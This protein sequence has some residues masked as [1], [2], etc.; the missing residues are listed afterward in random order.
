MEGEKSELPVASAE[1]P[2]GRQSDGQNQ[3]APKTMQSAERKV[4][5]I[6]MVSTLIL[7]VVLIALLFILRI[8]D[9]PLFIVAINY[10]RGRGV[11]VKQVHKLDKKALDLLAQ[12]DNEI[13]SADKKADDFTATLQNINERKK[14]EEFI[15]TIRLEKSKVIQARSRIEDIKAECDGY[16]LINIPIS[17][18][19]SAIE[20]A[21]TVERKLSKV[22]DAAYK[23]MDELLLK[24]QQANE[25]IINQTSNNTKDENNKQKPEK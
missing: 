21:K 9:K 7:L 3:Q 8:N 13:A 15:P 2:E 24:N 12:A 22:D 1:K 23:K 18:I 14:I 20:N 16:D 17:E 11:E 4:K 5:L 10:C 25:I 6:V 19:D